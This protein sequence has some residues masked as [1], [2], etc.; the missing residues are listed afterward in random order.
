MRSAIV[1]MN[2]RY[3]KFIE[4]GNQ[5][6]AEKYLLIDPD[7]KSEYYSAQGFNDNI[8]NVCRESSFT[9]IIKLL[10]KYT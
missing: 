1:S 2:A 6:E 5:E 8:M 7:D 10:M 3:Q 4:L 9:F